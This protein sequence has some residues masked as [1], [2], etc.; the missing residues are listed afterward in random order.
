MV[1]VLEKKRKMTHCMSRFQ[2]K[3]EMQQLLINIHT[4]YFS[5]KQEVNDSFYDLTM[6]SFSMGCSSS[7]AKIGTGFGTL[8]PE[9][10][11]PH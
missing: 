6:I 9:R 11:Q 1:L 4:V 8:C 7:L 2:C 10:R 3:V 5:S